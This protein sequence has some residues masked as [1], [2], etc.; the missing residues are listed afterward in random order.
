MKAKQ[1][2]VT[3]QSEKVKPHPL[4]YLK[5][6]PA[7]P[8]NGRQ[9]AEFKKLQQQA[10]LAAQAEWDAAHP[11]EVKK[12]RAEERRQLAKIKALAHKVPKKAYIPL[13]AEEILEQVSEG[14]D[15]GTVLKSLDISFSTMCYWFRTNPTFEV[16]FVKA[17]ENATHLLISQVIEISD[18]AKGKGE[19][20]KLKIDT[21]KWLAS[22]LLHKLYGERLVHSGD[23]D[24]PLVTKMVAD[25]KELL[26]KIRGAKP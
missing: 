1:P 21:R 16:A 14:G 4:G 25:S 12:R 18:N 11:E 2:T 8:V 26:A 20:E 22:K 13:F 9:A 5:P 3:E 15:L 17:R 24:N 19:L 23:V 7:K 10:D 6:R